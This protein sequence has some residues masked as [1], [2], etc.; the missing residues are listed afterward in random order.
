M[1]PITKIS[2]EL[3]PPWG[4]P[5]FTSISALSA[6]LG[7]HGFSGVDVREVPVELPLETPAQFVDLMCTRL[8]PLMS[9]LETSLSFGAKSKSTYQIS[10]SAS[11]NVA[12]GV[13]EQN[14]LKGYLDISTGVGGGAP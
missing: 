7:K 8:P 9:M 6:E 14:F 3:S 13:N 1:K 4:A 5:E 11:T 2:P 10:I 12:K